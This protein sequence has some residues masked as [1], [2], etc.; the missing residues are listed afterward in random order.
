MRIPGQKYGA[1]FGCMEMARSAFKEK[2]GLK[3]MKRK[4]PQQYIQTEEHAEELYKLFTK[5]LAVYNEYLMT[6]E[7]ATA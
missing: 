4:R 2:H 3:K 1:R 5:F 7:E 6:W